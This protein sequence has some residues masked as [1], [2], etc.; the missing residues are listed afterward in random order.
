MISVLP[1]GRDALVARPLRACAAALIGGFLCLAGSAA[2]AA[3]PPANTVIGNQ[4]SATYRDAAGNSQ[5]ATSNLVQTTVQQVGSFNLD[6]N[7]TNTTTVVNRK[8]G[9]PGTTVYA[10]HLLTNTGNGSD[11]FTLQV[12]APASPNGFSKVEVFADANADGLP[13]GTTPL[14]SATP[15]ASCDTPAQ[16]VAGN[17]GS[18]AFIVAYTIPGTANFSAPVSA[19][20]TAR[21]GTP[22]L[23]AANNQSASDVD[24]V[25]LTTAAAFNASKSLSVPA[26]NWSAN[27]GVWPVARNSG[28]RSNAN[29][30]ATAAGAA[31]P[32]PGCAYTTY[33]LR[34][35]NTGGAAGAFAL[36]DTLPGGFTYVPGSAVWSN[37]PGTALG[38]GAGGDP[39]GI[40]Y[41]VSGSTVTFVVQSL[42][43]NATQ[44]VSFVVL[45]N[46]TAAVGSS[47][48]TNRASYRPTVAADDNTTP[49]SATA[50]KSTP[51]QTNPA[52]YEVTGTF[53]LV[54]GSASGDPTA[55]L[56]SAAGEPNNTAADTT[57]V[58]NAL[59]GSTVRFTQRVFNTGNAADT[60]NLTVATPTNDGF[61]PGT[62]YAFY[63]ADGAT[64]LLDTNSDG[65]V[66]TGAIAT[67]ASR[68][69]VL[70][71]TLPS[72]N[73]VPPGPLSVIVQGTSAGDPSKSETTRDTLT[74][75]QGSLVDL[76]NS[77]EGTGSGHVGD[78][79]RGPGPGNLPTTREFVQEGSGQAAIFELY[80][81]NSDTIANT[82]RLDASQANSFPGT[83]P[84]GW[85]VKFVATGTNCAAAPIGSVSA[86]PGK[87]VHYR[88]CVTPPASQ[89]E[90]GAASA[91]LMLGLLLA[92]GSALAAPPPANTVIGN[93]ASA[94]Y[95]DPNGASQTATSNLVQT[96]VQQVGAF[97]LDGFSTETTTVVNNKTG[98]AGATVY[99]PHVLTNT[100]NGSD[101]FTISVVDAP[102]T[103]SKV[104][105][106][107]DANADGLPDNTT[108]L[109]T[110][111]PNGANDC[112]FTT[113]AVAG[114]NGSFPFVVAYSIPGTASG[115]SFPSPQAATVRAVPT[116]TSL[117][118]SGNQAA[119]DV[120]SGTGAPAA[121]TTTG[122]G[123][124]VASMTPSTRNLPDLMC[125]SE[126]VM[127]VP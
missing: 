96:T 6:G 2:S 113:P 71:V 73:P 87:Q 70:A 5:I 10:P 27:N 23:Y 36:T 58:A 55:S 116:T 100:G 25:S 112:T 79:D 52:S 41:A 99:A 30:A 13:D 86:D 125:G 59:V 20:V 34:F 21:P 54:L 66:D 75:M 88:A 117:Y 103:F 26:V 64:P 8:S 46:S 83:L 120:D 106:F 37:A 4:A 93:Q 39:A 72:P 97:T 22:A 127:D 16:Q 31:N 89:R 82:Y 110:V 84:A 118:A 29:C 77:P 45:V 14:C 18:L 95:Q 62:R 98:A 53:G 1:R 105:V 111:T 15:S 109:C 3:P 28:P 35:N 42:P 76:T 49:P 61:P 92:S 32:A 78:G 69:V 48:T 80:V 43:V 90:F 11:S 124:A 17:N 38:D 68:Q 12:A 19:T 94:T 67:G 7:T 56:D 65:I 107:A 44:T 33:T 85:T 50:P 57:T 115:T 74:Q 122:S 40:D 91:A 104:E 47:T 60:V 108:A 114:N 101:T 51:A 102:A 81:R 123:V 9:A 63:A 121:V 119:A 126:L 24:E